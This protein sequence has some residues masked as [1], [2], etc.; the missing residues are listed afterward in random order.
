MTFTEAAITFFWAL[1]LACGAVFCDLII[2]AWCGDV[3][4]RHGAVASFC[5]M[6]VIGLGLDK[7][8]GNT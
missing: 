4:A 7:L 3:I 2:P 5:G 8:E 1:F 6:V